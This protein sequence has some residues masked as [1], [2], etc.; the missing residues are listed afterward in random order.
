MINSNVTPNANQQP[1]PPS[2]EA[3]MAASG[4][5]FFQAARLLPK[6]VRAGV[7]ALYAFCRYVDDLADES[8]QSLAVR[9]QQLHHLQQALIE[10]RNEDSARVLSMLYDAVQLSPSGL[11]AASVLVG[12]AREDLSQ[13]QPQTETELVSYA[14]GVAGTVGL[15]M[16]EV[17]GAQ[18]QG[19]RAAI[20]LGIAMQLSN[21]ARDVGQD[22]RA[23]RVYLP[24]S[25]IASTDVE[26]ALT[27]HDEAA[28]KAL[29][30]ATLRL[31][32][33]ADE[34]YDSA[35]TGFWTLPLRV[36]WSIL[37]AALCYR[38]IGVYVGK[39]IKASWRGRTIVP[40][41]RKVS[42]IAFAGAKLLLPKY[43]TAQGATTSSPG[44]ELL[45]RLAVLT[46][47]S[48]IL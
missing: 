14:F 43:W 45:D 25:W 9:S 30:S 32:S 28:Q 34:C 17:L 7:V 16:G 31:L 4:K 24:A 37:S 47:P 27:Q 20:E 10:G 39:N 11:R 22:L 15:M 42:L 48:E 38:E 3:V 1:A 23:G 44:L 40:R 8:T 21:I 29:V 26:R 18:K 5:T 13:K 35:F 2:A 46:I 41:W 6:N 19:T 33:L 12:A 36:R